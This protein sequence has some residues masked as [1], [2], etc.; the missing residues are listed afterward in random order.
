MPHRI[1]VGSIFIECNH[2]GGVPAD[3]EAFRRSELRFGADVVDAPGGTVAGM[4]QHLAETETAVCPLLVASACPSGPVTAE[5]YEFLKG[6]LLKRL[7]DSTP[8]DG[9]LLA[10]HGSAAAENAGDLEG[11]LLEAVRAAVGP[12]VPIVA[13]LD[14]H[15]HVTERMVKNADALLAWETYPHR[16]AFETGQRGATALL[17]I[18]SGSI[19]P[20]MAYARVP[21][22]VG[23]IHGQTEG[24]GPFADV[25]R[26]TKSLEGQGTVYS[27]GAFLVHPYLDL[28]DMGGGGLVVTNNDPETAARLA[29]EIAS[30]YWERRFELEPD[31]VTP[32][33]AIRKSAYIDGGP[34]LL[35]ETADC[36]GGGAAGDSVATLK[37]LLAAEPPGTSL[38]PVVDPAAAAECHSARAGATVSLTLGHQRDPRFGTPIKINGT[39][40]RV[41]D[42]GFVYRGGIW[43]GQTGQMGPT[44]VVRV[45]SVEIL[46]ASHGT[47]DWC[48]EQFES[49]GLDEAAARFVVVKNPMNYSMAYGEIAKAIF[50]LDTPGPTPASIRST[51]F[52]NLKRPYFPLD[53]SIEGLVPTVLTSW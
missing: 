46:I 8:I 32:E 53:Q 24:D 10:L 44:A 34:I 16:D 28:P 6:D 26:F 48:G 19:R 11:D 49:V 41:T 36:C 31:V 21:V 9:V 50:I 22:V 2:L 35:V 7:A 51:T 30:M 1:A 43:D 23:A 38:V 4:L 40:I 15:A 39:V 17:E 25:M 14:L 18:L 3:L 20:T 47:Y 13:T 45:G 37:A 12:D 27:T 5:C 42:G 29:T 52:H 33:E